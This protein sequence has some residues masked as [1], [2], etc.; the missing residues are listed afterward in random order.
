MYRIGY[1]RPAGE[2][3]WE[4]RIVGPRDISI[5]IRQETPG[6]TTEEIWTWL[7]DKC[8]ALNVAQGMMTV[9]RK[10]G[11]T[12]AYKRWNTVDYGARRG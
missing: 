10:R 9:I 3:V 5:P 6:A 2:C 4:G 8:D 7:Q 12:G 1:L 11:P